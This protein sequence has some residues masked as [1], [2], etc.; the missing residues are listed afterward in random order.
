MTA[1]FTLPES[2]LAKKPLP[3]TL[4]VRAAHN[5]VYVVFTC[6]LIELGPFNVTIGLVLSIQVTVAVVLP[7][8]LAASLNSKENAPFAVNR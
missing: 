5:S 6:R 1:V 7:V 8:L 4:S 3:S 2:G